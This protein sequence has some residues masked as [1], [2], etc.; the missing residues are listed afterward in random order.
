[1]Y[2]EMDPTLLPTIVKKGSSMMEEGSIKKEN[3][4]WKKVLLSGKSI[5]TIVGVL[6]GI[7][8]MCLHFGPE[9][10]TIPKTLG[11]LIIMATCWVTE[12]LPLS[13][14]ALFPV[15]LCPLLGIATGKSIASQYFNDTI[16][17]FMSG[18][19]LSL[20]M[21]RWNL[22]M[23]IALFITSCFERPARSSSAS[24]SP[25]GSCRCGSPTRQPRS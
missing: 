9:G 2:C 22:H 25:R 13:V 14:T 8:L 7:I 19:L 10:S 6:V 16:F 24:C 12:V 3:D 11:V 23:R 17:M 21:E 5:G 18:F 4:S 20:A 1:M 15:I